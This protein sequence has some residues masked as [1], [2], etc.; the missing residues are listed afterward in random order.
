VSR[1]RFRTILKWVIGLLVA[2]IALLVLAI[3]FKSPILKMAICST[4]KS[5]TGLKAN[6]GQ[7]DLDLGRSQLAI[8]NFQIFNSPAFGNSILL[9]IPEIYLALES[10]DAAS[11]KI[12]FKEIRFNMQEL[13]V[14]Q[15]TNGVTNLELLQKTFETNSAKKGQAHVKTI[16][17]GG[18]DKIVVNLGKVKFTDLGNSANNVE[19]NLGVTN[20]TALN[21]K[22]E[23]E[24]QNWAT[25]LLLRLAIQQ[26][27]DPESRK[28]LPTK[29]KT[30]VPH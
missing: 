15:N 7:F 21:L 14:V 5:S 20:A 26:W 28:S 11:G 30:L 29:W 16:E 19:M 17:F 23:E 6:I 8:S 2:L 13:H 27:F 1:G 24:M 3:I 22:S 12:R 9:D 18:V 10:Q 25:A 4:V